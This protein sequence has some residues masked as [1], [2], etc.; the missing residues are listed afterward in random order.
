MK[1]DARHYC[2]AL[3]AFGWQVQAAAQQLM[4]P[5]AVASAPTQQSG[6]VDLLGGL[7]YTDNARLSSSHRTSDGI[8]IAGLNT[9][10]Q[11]TGE[12]SLNLLGNL[13]RIQY[14]QGSYAGSFYGQFFGS[15]VLGKPTDFLQ[16][17]LSDAFGEEMTNPLESPTPQNLQTINNVATGPLLNFHFGFTNRLTL[18][19]VYSRTTYERSPFDSQ[20]YQGGA[21]FQH[22]LPGASTI[23]LYASTAHTTY[24][25]SAAVRSYFSGNTAYDIR[26]A[27]LSYKAR[28]VR[29]RV[30]LTMG[31]NFLQYGG[32][33]THGA[34]LYR[35][36]LSRQISPFSKVFIGGGQAYST[37]GASLESPGARVGLQLGAS[38]N[39]GYAVA[40][41]FNERSADVGW[42]F[43]RARTSLTVSGNYR[44]ELF[45]Q[46][47]VNH[48]FDHRDEGAVIILE[49]QLRPRLSVRLRA[50][51][52]WQ[53]YS[54][55]S[56]QTRREDV[57]LS[58]SK[59]LAKT[60]IWFYVERIHQS[61][62]P[63]NSGFFAASYNDDRVGIYLTY[64]LFGERPM[65][66]SSQ[67]MLGMSE[68]TGGY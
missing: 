6:Y 8:A 41:P 62:V 12:L 32:A 23:S 37:N 19:G 5:A 65:L 58:F 33:P 50:Q 67:E 21:Q 24:I 27:S 63:G 36:R 60:M 59:R 52:Y 1:I 53:D 66:S 57:Q 45:G 7:A 10:Y 44:Q 3:L 64:D 61:G 20:T 39:A 16:W 15:G 48:Q 35:V 2:L 13:A 31:Y 49:R 40:Q 42:I 29:T 9:N 55:L 11:R 51:G 28:Y 38:L 56:A 46:T 30:L 68:F 43:Q 25:D 18:S 22:T 4:Q 17:Q 47:S 26:Q 54:Q 34:P 14:L